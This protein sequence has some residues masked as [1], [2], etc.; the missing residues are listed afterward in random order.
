MLSG[1]SGVKLD[2]CD[3]L[4][5]VAQLVALNIKNK[6]EFEVGGLMVASSCLQGLTSEARAALF[7]QQFVLPFGTKP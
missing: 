1:A 4:D 5:R 2:R 6:S 3:E 7:P